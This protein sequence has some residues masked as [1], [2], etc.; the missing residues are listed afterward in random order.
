[1]GV[2][3]FSKL[4]HTESQNKIGPINGGTVAWSDNVVSVPA[5]R[6]KLKSELET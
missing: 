5:G 1:M 3:F 4:N 6:R 2:N